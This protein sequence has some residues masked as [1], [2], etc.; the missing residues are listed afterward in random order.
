MVTVINFRVQE[1]Q[2][3]EKFCVLILQ[4]G[5]EM[6]RSKETKRFY[7]TARR[8][9]TPSTFDEMTCKALIGEKMPGSIGKVTCDE[10]DFTIP[11]TGEIVKLKHR[12][13]Y[14]PEGETAQQT[15]SPRN[16][17]AQNGGAMVVH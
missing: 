8:T 9:S 13:E 11:Q 17:V 4:G 12:W 15:S 16:I 2:K 5:I 7:A 6:V 14:I 3:G 1:N 10:Y